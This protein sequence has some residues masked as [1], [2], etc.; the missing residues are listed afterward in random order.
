MRL[1]QRRR[2]DCEAEVRGLDED[3]QCR[4]GHI[5]TA[6]VGSFQPN[7]FGLYDMHGN[8]WEWVQDCWNSGYGGAPEYGSAWTAGATLDCGRR[9]LR[10][11]SWSNEPR[12]LRSAKRASNRV[13]N[14]TDDRVDNVGFRVGRTLQPEPGRSR[15]HR[16]STERPAPFMKIA[17]AGMTKLA[18]PR[19][20]TAAPVSGDARPPSG[21]RPAV[22]ARNLQTTR[23]RIDLR[24]NARSWHNPE[25][26]GGAAI[27][28]GYRVTYTVPATRQHACS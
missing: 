5:N 14:T 27:P 13:R 24:A 18:S 20:A 21:A 12:Y 10:G 3:S 2:S 26:F 9:V 1:R 8:V 15:S 22:W 23:S 25:D 19:T 4:D 6:P 28:S 17:D 16:A 11:G 7:A